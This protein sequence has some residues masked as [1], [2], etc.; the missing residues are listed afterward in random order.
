[1]RHRNQ[2][3]AGPSR[4]AV[5][6]SHKSGNIHGMGTDSALPPGGGDRADRCADVRSAES[7]FLSSSSSPCPTVRVF[8]FFINGYADSFV[9]QRRKTSATASFSPQH[10]FLILN[11]VSF[12]TLSVSQQCHCLHNVLASTTYLPP[13]RESRKRNRAGRNS[14]RKWERAWKKRQTEQDDPGWRDLSGA[15]CA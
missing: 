8:R 6:D 9:T 4:P 3:D 14:F 12:T 7:A 1:M 5:F 11:I 10:H 13:R 2:D 15:I